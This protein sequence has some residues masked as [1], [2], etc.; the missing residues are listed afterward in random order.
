MTNRYQKQIILPEI[1]ESG[2]KKIE[3]ASVLIV[4][5]GGLGVIVASYLV[6]MGIGNIGIS[7]F[8][9]VQESNLHRQL[10]FTPSDIGK[11]KVS[12]LVNKLRLQNPDIIINSINKKIEKNS[13]L[14]IANNYQIICDCT[15]QSFSRIIINDY[16]INNNKILVHGAVSD[17]QGYV[18]VF[19]YLK[20]FSL[21]DIFNFSDYIEAQ[22]CTETGIISPVCGI[23]GSYMTNE[24]IKIILKLDNVLDGKI[25]YFNIFNN[26]IRQINIKKNN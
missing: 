14:E 8:D 16:C 13:I 1:G 23:I 22:S 10:H 19:N 18:T 21:K 11:S 24:T 25:L 4:G 12:V 26:Q 15:D 2:Q 9:N 20:G 7:D 17:W 6:A 5:A 3:N